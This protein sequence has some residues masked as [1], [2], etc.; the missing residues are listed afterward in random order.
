MLPG[1]VCFVVVA[2]F[3]GLLESSI[4]QTLGEL[5]PSL[6]LSLFLHQGLQ[7]HAP[8]EPVRL[9]TGVA[10]KALVVKTFGDCHSLLATH[11]KK[12]GCSFLKFNGRERKRLVLP[13]RLLL[14]LGNLCYLGS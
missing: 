5:A 14:N 7:V 3:P 10:D 11:P 8:V 13:S 1:A 4:N 9:G 2:A 12:T 6:V